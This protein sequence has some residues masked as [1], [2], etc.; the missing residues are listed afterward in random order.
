MIVCA[1]DEQ[2]GGVC[3]KKGGGNINARKM[4]KKAKDE[5]VSVR[6]DLNEKVLSEEEVCGRMA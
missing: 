1:C 3:R 5:V 6:V 4:E 2:R